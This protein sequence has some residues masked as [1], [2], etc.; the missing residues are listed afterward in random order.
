MKRIKTIIKKFLGIDFTSRK[1]LYGELI[2]CYDKIEEQEKYIKELKRKVNQNI[3]ENFIKEEEICLNEDYISSEN[4][5]EDNDY[6][7]TDIF[8][9]D[10][11]CSSVVT[12]D[13]PLVCL[14]DQCF[15]HCLT[16][17]EDY[18]NCSDDCEFVNCPC[19]TMGDYGIDEKEEYSNEEYTSSD[20]I[21]KDEYNFELSFDVEVEK[22]K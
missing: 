2:N 10:N 6:N 1:K 9:C 13:C 5:E 11:D 21:D 19:Y 17:W 22:F 4:I 16:D 20:V 3:F 15:Y 12:E 18:Y 8:N 7:S 14:N